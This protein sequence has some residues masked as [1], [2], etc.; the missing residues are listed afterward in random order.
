MVVGLPKMESKTYNVIFMQCQDMLG[1]N[2]HT[3]IYMYIHTHSG[4]DV[5]ITRHVHT[6][7]HTHVHID[8]S[9]LLPFIGIQIAQRFTLQN[10]FVI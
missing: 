6:Y 4:I 7:I 8:K 10:V 3:Q 5:Y 2:K 1:T 9:G